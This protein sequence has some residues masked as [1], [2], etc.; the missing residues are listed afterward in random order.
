MSYKHIY[1]YNKKKKIFELYDTFIYP[2]YI[3]GQEISKKKLK[4]QF[5]GASP[6]I[7]R[8]LRNMSFMRMNIGILKNKF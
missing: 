2:Y 8:Y 5:F 3:Y 4:F 1:I 6:L 7:H